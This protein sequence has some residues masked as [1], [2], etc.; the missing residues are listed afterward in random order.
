[1]PTYPAI[2]RSRPPASIACDG[3]A[4]GRPHGAGAGATQPAEG[5][6]GADPS[7][8]WRRCPFRRRLASFAA[9]GQAPPHPD[10]ATRVAPRARHVACATW[11]ARSL[12]VLPCDMACNVAGAAQHTARSAAQ[13]RRMRRAAS[14][15]R[16]AHYRPRPIPSAMADTPACADG[17]GGGKAR[18]W[19]S[20]SLGL[21]LGYP[22]YPRVPL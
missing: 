20:T 14:S 13:G 18:R 19:C 16:T 9:A 11:R 15:R 7:P 5:R 10:N 4:S 2:H 21:P 8:C 1:V 12:L 6:P 22:Q 17:D 3:A